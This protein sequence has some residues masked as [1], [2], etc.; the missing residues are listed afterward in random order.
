[1]INKQEMLMKSNMRK[2]TEWTV[3]LDAVT[4]MAEIT[5]IIEKK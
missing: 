3:F 5:A 1:M 4:M 2:K